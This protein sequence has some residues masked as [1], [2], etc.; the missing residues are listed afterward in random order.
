MGARYSKLAAGGDGDGTLMTSK[1]CEWESLSQF[2]H[3]VVAVQSERFERS[4]EAETNNEHCVMKELAASLRKST[5]MT[6]VQKLHLCDK[7]GF[8]E[9]ID[10]IEEEMK[11][12]LALAE[13]LA[14]G[15]AGDPVKSAAIVKQTKNRWELFLALEGHEKTTTPNDDM[16]KAYTN[17][18]FHF[19]QYRSKIGR[20]GLGDQAAEAAQKYLAQVRVQRGVYSCGVQHGVYSCGASPRSFP[21]HMRRV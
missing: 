13:D 4:N 5:T 20:Q 8:E 1:G 21:Y 16:V 11:E 18:M 19:R 7:L 3:G 15:E 10:E 2:E 9:E 6:N 17:F 14:A 12:E